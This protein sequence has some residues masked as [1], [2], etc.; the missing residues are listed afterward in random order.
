MK[1]PSTEK[2]DFWCYLIGI[3][4]AWQGKKERGEEDYGGRLS[5]A[6]YG[7]IRLVIQLELCERFCLHLQELD[8]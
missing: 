6:I 3:E 8:A 2:D 5:R 1:R 7:A 4:R